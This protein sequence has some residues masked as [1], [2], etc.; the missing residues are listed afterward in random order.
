M[1]PLSWRHQQYQSIA[2]EC[3]MM[4]TPQR[5]KVIHIRMHFARDVFVLQLNMQTSTVLCA[6]T[7]LHHGLYLAAVR[8]IFS[9]GITPPHAPVGKPL[10]RCLVPVRVA[11]TSAEDEPSERR[12][13]PWAVRVLDV[14]K[15]SLEHNGDAAAEIG[16][17]RVTPCS[18]M[19][20][21]KGSAPL[22]AG[23]LQRLL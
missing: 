3:R 8:T 5:Q 7:A 2:C 21:I 22:T 18:N 4:N 16:R 9:S 1:L 14:C 6:S 20:V 15:T 19:L 10:I 13:V 23:Y 12:D 11:Y 17:S